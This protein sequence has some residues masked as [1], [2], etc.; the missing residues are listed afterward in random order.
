MTYSMDFARAYGTP[1]VAG[2]LRGQPQDFYVRERLGF[3][4]AGA[5]EHLYLYVRKTGANTEWAANRIAHLAGIRAL[6]VGYA[7]RKDRN[8]VT[9]QWFSCQLPGQLP[10]D[11]RPL[12]R[13]GIEV[14]CARRHPRKLRPG[15]H[16]ANRFRI[17]VRALE[18][19]SAAMEDLGRRVEALGRA[20]F[21]NYFGEQRFGREGANLLHANELMR[22]IEK[23]RRDRGMYISAA[24]SY[25]FNRHLSGCVESGTWHMPAAFGWLP[26]I[27]RTGADIPRDDAFYD[28]YEGLERLGV[29]AMRRTLCVVPDN[30]ESSIE[31]QQLELSF[32]LPVGSYAT[33]LLRELVDYR[34]TGSDDAGTG[35]HFGQIA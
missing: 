35:G 16:A 27:S 5:G 24:R 6:R 23:H 12:Q 3:E 32:D 31:G 28:W 33:S 20:G 15:M 11:W 30:L 17:R 1:A 13:D 14:L 22:G 4:P 34:E 9:E 26:G 18:G 25:L 7:G 19:G 21:P 29:R 2:I 8:A 10:P